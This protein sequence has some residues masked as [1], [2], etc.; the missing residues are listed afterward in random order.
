MKYTSVFLVGAFL[1]LFVATRA[2]AETDHQCATET[3]AASRVASNSTTPDESEPS[4]SG[5]TPDNAGRG[6]DDYSGYTSD[7][8]SRGDASP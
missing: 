2:W 8:G 3:E 7:G 4:T 6:V 5:S 1:F